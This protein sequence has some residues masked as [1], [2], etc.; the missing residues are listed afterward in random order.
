VVALSYIDENRVHLGQAFAV[1]L[2]IRDVEAPGNAADMTT[3][4]SGIPM[5]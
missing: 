5:S 2:R 3:N 1:R 4:N